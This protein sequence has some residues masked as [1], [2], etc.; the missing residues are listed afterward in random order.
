MPPT[1]EPHKMRVSYPNW[2]NK[3]AAKLVLQFFDPKSKTRALAC[4]GVWVRILRCENGAF[5]VDWQIMRGQGWRVNGSV[6]FTEKQFVDAFGLA[7]E[8]REQKQRKIN[9]SGGRFSVEGVYYRYT[10]YL[11]IP[12]GGSGTDTDINA[13]IHLT[14]DIKDAVR[15][16]LPAV[17]K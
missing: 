4:P 15:S 6:L 10:D 3:N 11:N 8:P 7:E 13:S 12:H 14:K 2:F 16:L 1:K 17:P 9:G 5:Q